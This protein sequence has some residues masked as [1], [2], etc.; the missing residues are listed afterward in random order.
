MFNP[1]KQFS[2]SAHSQENLQAQAQKAEQKVAEAVEPVPT[3]GGSTLILRRDANKN[4][5]AWTRQF[6][7]LELLRYAEPFAE[8]NTA[9]QFEG[10]D[11]KTVNKLMDRKLYTASY[12]GKNKNALGRTI[13][14]NSD[15]FLI[16][17]AAIEMH[18]SCCGGED[19]RGYTPMEE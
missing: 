1:F 2:S 6:V 10:V 13:V 17:L 11:F 5:K 4:Y 16:L 18:R 14:W 8:R 7:T 19:G 3:E 12:E 9:V 15:S